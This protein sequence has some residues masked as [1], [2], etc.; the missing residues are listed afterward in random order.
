MNVAYRPLPSSNQLY[1]IAQA[2]I[3]ANAQAT[4]PLV[5]MNGASAATT[6][7]LCARI[8]RVSGTLALMIGALNLNGIVVQAVSAVQSALMG[9]SADPIQYPLSSLVSVGVMP[10][11]GAYSF[12]VGTINGGAASVLVQVYGFKIP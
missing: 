5:W 7:P 12:T 2:T 4:T 3:D 6:V 11:A 9:S 1:L 8:T 10:A